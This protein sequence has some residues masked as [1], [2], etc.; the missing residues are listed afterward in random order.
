VD[1]E[2]Q[3]GYYRADTFLWH[4][5]ER[6]R[7]ELPALQTNLKGQ[8]GLSFNLPETTINL[9]SFNSPETNIN[10]KSLNLPETAN[11]WWFQET[12]NG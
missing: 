7:V 10:L 6:P 4:S 11:K 2:R 12:E 3:R 9:I 8:I 1:N 5:N